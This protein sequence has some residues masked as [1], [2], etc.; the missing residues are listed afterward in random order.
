MDP[1]LPHADRVDTGQTELHFVS[2]PRDISVLTN[3]VLSK[4]KTCCLLEWS[5]AYICF[6]SFII[7]NVRIK[8]NSVYP[9]QDVLKEQS[10]LG[11]H[12]KPFQEMT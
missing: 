7:F 9:D 4:N 2:L 6:F 3:K 1:N 10:D 5:T 8:A 11:I 12:G